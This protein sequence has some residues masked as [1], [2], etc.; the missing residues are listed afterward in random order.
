LQAGKHGWGGEENGG[1]PLE[2]ERG[3]NDNVWSAKSNKTKNK[4]NKINSKQ[5][6]N[7]K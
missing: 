1:N 2:V 7:K 5:K 6:L 4:E 3:S